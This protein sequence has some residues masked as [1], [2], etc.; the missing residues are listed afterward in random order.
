MSE[1]PPPSDVI[2][3]VED[4]VLARHAIAQYLR[5]CGHVVIE[6][7]S[8][9]EA[10]TILSQPSIRVDVVLSG[11]ELGAGMDG[12]ALAGWLRENRPHVDVVLAGTAT[13]AAEE[14]GELCDEGPHLKRPYEPQQVVD[15]IRKLRNLKGPRGSDKQP[16]GNNGHAPSPN[17]DP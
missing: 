16:A 14:A 2:L 15:W 11:V 9:E 3:I 5:H 7:A 1:A 8:A 12:F 17:R 13:K 6:A 10:L 4:D